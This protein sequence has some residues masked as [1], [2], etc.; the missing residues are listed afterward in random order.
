MRT[1]TKKGFSLVELVSVL[2]VIVILSSIGAVSY[3]KLTQS[4]ESKVSLTALSALQLEGRRLARDGMFPTSILEDLPELAGYTYVGP[5]VVA[6]AQQIS[7]LRVSDTVVIYVSGGADGC[8]GVV[9]RLVGS[10]TWAIDTAT[11]DL[12]SAN[13]ASGKLLAAP[14][15]GSATM[16]QQVAMHA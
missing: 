1:F 2:V 13:F 6:S 12:C 11:A 3:T 14:A 15:G 10:S 9:D 7:V 5:A 4:T 8:V 16:L